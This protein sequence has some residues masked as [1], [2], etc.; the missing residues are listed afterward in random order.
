MLLLLSRYQATSSQEKTSSQVRH[1]C[2]LIHY[3]SQTHAR[4]EY[5]LDGLFPDE[6]SDSTPQH[7]PST[8]KHGDKWYC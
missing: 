1:C 2:A 3:P 8:S 7:Q 4:V 5:T 6:V